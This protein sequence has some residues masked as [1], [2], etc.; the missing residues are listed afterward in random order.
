MVGVEPAD[1]ATLR[2]EVTAQEWDDWSTEDPVHPVALVEDG[3]LVAAASLGPW[4]GR[5]LDVGVVT[6]PDRRGRG[7]A[8]RVGRTCASYAVRE[9]GVAL[10]RAALTNVASVRAAERIGFE[11]YVTQ[12][13][14]RPPVSGS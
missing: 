10:W 3:R 9:H 11:R 12:L 5:V 2:P 7:L 4:D 14:L 1:L 13:A 8:T 6:V